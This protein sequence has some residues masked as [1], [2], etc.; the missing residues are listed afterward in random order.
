[1]SSAI[2]TIP[3]GAVLPAKVLPKPPEFAAAPNPAHESAPAPKLV[4][5]HHAAA[6][7]AVRH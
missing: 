7:P 6:S 1:M 3:V 5:H 4:K 2:P